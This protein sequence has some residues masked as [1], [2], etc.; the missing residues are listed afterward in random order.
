[1][2]DYATIFGEAIDEEK[3][4]IKEIA[5]IAPPSNDSIRSPRHQLFSDLPTPS[6]N[7]ASFSGMSGFA[8]LSGQGKAHRTT[9][10]PQIHHHQQQPPAS[11]FSPGQ[12]NGVPQAFGSSQYT[13]QGQAAQQQQ[14]Q[15]YE[16]YRP[17]YHSNHQHQPIY[18]MQQNG[19]PEANYGSLNMLTS[20][21]PAPQSMGATLSVAPDPKRNRRESAMMGFDIGLV[22]QRHPVR[23]LHEQ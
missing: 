7:Q 13:S 6:Y 16:A 22:G 9:Y 18:N 19:V 14:Q 17:S 5:Y 15:Q 3:S 1:L 11:P 2:T 12:Q 8:P 23:G 4:P 10:M 21:P 20:Q